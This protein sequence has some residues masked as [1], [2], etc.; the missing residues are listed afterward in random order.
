MPILPGIVPLQLS[1]SCEDVSELNCGEE[2]ASSD[3]TDSQFKIE[4]P[5]SASV[6]PL[7]GGAVTS[8]GADNL[9]LTPS[10]NVT[11]VV[12]RNLS[13]LKSLELSNKLEDLSAARVAIN[14]A[15]FD[16]ARKDLKVIDENEVKRKAPSVYVSIFKG[17]DTSVL[18]EGATNPLMIRICE[19]RYLPIE[20]FQEALDNILIDDN[21]EFNDVVGVSGRTFQELGDKAESVAS[22]GGSPADVT[23]LILEFFPVVNISEDAI[24]G[25]ENNP[26]IGGYYTIYKDKIYLKMPDLSS[27]DSSGRSNA[28]IN[29]ET[30]LWYEILSGAT[31][32]RS[33]I[34][35]FKAPP[36]ASLVGSPPTEFP[37]DSSLELEIELAEEESVTVYLSPVVKNL[38][39]NK[40]R[41][42]NTF[43]DFIELFA[44]R[45]ILI[46]TKINWNNTD[47]PFFDKINKVEGNINIL[48]NAMA[49]PVGWE[50]SKTNWVSLDV[51]DYKDA[52]RLENNLLLLKTM[53]DNIGEGL[54]HCGS[55]SCGKNTIL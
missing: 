49:Q 27:R 25:N 23:D 51:F 55:F 35:N 12:T 20:V 42:L 29:S 41:S 11:N 17:E 38:T 34:A 37:S 28:V 36:I 48:K 26:V 5:S 45:P 13:V 6:L 54:L 43:P 50:V 19:F 2:G 47:F 30:S 4:F 16:I 18:R 32:T 7:A 24:S 52:I 22:G 39:V 44:Q 31:L 3:N 21:V 46:D 14:N 8:I 9:K 33:E 10:K 53:A 1:D 15:L 40:R